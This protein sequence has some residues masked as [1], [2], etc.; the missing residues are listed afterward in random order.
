MDFTNIPTAEE[1]FGCEGC[2]TPY[3]NLVAMLTFVRDEIK[4]DFLVW[5]GD[6][7]KGDT[8]SNTID[9]VISYV[10]N[11]TGTIK[12]LGVDKDI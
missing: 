12:A 10:V 5:T 7:S 2:Q 9:E 4:P 3:V 11:V 6:N 8:W 1:P